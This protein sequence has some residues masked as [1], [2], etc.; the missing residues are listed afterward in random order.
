MTAS[1]A[2][3]LI[4]AQ[5]NMFDPDH[6]VNAAGELLETLAGLVELPWTWHSG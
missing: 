4:D 3:V 6:P 5:V 1:T 2:L